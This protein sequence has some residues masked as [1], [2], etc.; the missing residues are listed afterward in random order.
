MDITISHQQLVN[1]LELLSRISAKHVTLPVLQC[2]RVTATEGEVTL[3]ATNLEVSMEVKIPAEVSEFGEAAVPAQTFLQS[4]QFI[5]QSTITLRTE[6]QVLQIESEATNTSIKLLPLD[7]FPTLKKIVGTELLVGA[8]LFSLGIKSVAS[9]ASQTSIKPELGSVCIQQKKEHTLTFV[10]TDSF[11]LMEKTVPQKNIVLDQVLMVPYKNALE[12]ARV[13]DVAG[14]EVIMT[15]NE[16]QCAFTFKN[17]VYVSTRLVTGSFPDYEQIIPKEFSTH[18][19]VLK[20]DLQKSFKKTATFLNKFRQVTLTVTNKN[21][22]V[23]AQ[24]NDVGH[25]TNSIMAEVSGDDLTLSFNQ[26]YIMDPLG[27]LY[28]DS[29]KMSFAGIGRA[30]VMRGATDTTV[31][32]LVMPMN[33]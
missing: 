11:R 3:Q 33:K 1:G 22:T 16:N 31:R 30:L 6:D 19:T 5:S 9:S 27:H 13:C 32:Y 28:D 4:I 10:A 15:I 2:V 7:E 14:G 12:V 23:A 26:Q 24:N 21:V 18:A 17:G 20:D 29:I 8:E 25:T